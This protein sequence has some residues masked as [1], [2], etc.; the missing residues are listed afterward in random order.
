MGEGGVYTNVWGGGIN[1][2]AALKNIEDRKN[3]TGK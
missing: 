2:H 3:T 1:M